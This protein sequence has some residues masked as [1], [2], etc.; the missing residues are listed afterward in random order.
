M[1]KERSDSVKYG[2]ADQ[3]KQKDVSRCVGGFLKIADRL[4]LRTAKERPLDFRKLLLDFSSFLR[5]EKRSQ[6]AER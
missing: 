5:G 1:R 2:Q 6:V 3:G 4:S